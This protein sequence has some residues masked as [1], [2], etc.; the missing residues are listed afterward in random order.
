MKIRDII[1]QAK[2]SSPIS[3]YITATIVGVVIKK[4]KGGKSYFDLTFRDDSGSVNAK[5]FLRDESML[6]AVQ[7]MYAVNTILDVNGT[8]DK[9]YK[10]MTVENETIVGVVELS[11]GPRAC[12]IPGTGELVPDHS[13]AGWMHEEGVTGP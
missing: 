9:K 1:E 5:K 3:V 4:T 7:R 12:L 6:P 2:H 11:P 13:G 8:Y 10:S